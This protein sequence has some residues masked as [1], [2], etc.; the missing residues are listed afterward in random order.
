MLKLNDSFAAALHD[1]TPRVNYQELPNSA[2]FQYAPFDMSQ[3][4]RRTTAPVPQQIEQAPARPSIAQRTYS[5]QRGAY[6]DPAAA[7][8]YRQAQEMGYAPRTGPGMMPPRARTY[9]YTPATPAQ[10]SP[11]ESSAYVT[12]PSTPGETTG[13]QGSQPAMAPAGGASVTGTN[14]RFAFPVQQQPHDIG[15]NGSAER[16]AERERV[17]PRKDEVESVPGPARTRGG[18]HVASES[19]AHT[20]TSRRDRF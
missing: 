14:G 20:H 11:D 7:L 3:Y 9:S 15:Q 19:S 16:W 8:R 6:A 4:V 12:E 10:R 5:D 17:G 13:G 2:T 1:G 18:S